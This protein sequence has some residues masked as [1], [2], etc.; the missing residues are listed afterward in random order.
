MDAAARATEYLKLGGRCP[1]KVGKLKFMEFGLAKCFTFS[2]YFFKEIG[3]S[4]VISKQNN[5]SKR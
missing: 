4:R 5:F 2:I 1:K 3:I